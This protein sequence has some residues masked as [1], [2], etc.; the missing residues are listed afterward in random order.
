MSVDSDK[1]VSVTAASIKVDERGEI[2]AES[3]KFIYATAEGE[4]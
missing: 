1:I 4:A 3:A 2:G